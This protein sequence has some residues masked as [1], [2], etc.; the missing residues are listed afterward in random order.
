M[1]RNDLT[2]VAFAD[3]G[4]I[5]E[6]FE[7]SFAVISTGASITIVEAVAHGVP[8]IRMIPDNT[9]LLDP[10]VWEDY[11]LQ[12]VSHVEE[13]RKQLAIISRIKTEDDGYFDRIGMKVSAE[14]FARPDDRNMQIFDLDSEHWNRPG[15][16]KELGSPG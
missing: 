6:W 1:E 14:Y 3:G 13:I 16:V 11:P 2:D 5:Q 4:G 12:P 7:D 15:D 10:L 8:V 9:F